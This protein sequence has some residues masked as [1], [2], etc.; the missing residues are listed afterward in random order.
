[1]PYLEAGAVVVADKAEERLGLRLVVPALDILPES[2]VVLVGFVLFCCF[3]C[4]CFF[5]GGGGSDV[6]V[7]E[8]RATTLPRCLAVTVRAAKDRP[9]SG[10]STVYLESVGQKSGWH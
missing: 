1:M 4:C 5:L 8:M 2:C 6:T 10:L 9:S 7:L 3:F